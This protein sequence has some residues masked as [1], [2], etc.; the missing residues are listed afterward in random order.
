MTTTRIVTA[1]GLTPL[2]E[3]AIGDVDVAVGDAR[4]DTARYDEPD[5]VY[6]GLA[7]EFVDA[8]CNVIEAA[9]YCG[10]ERTI[11]AFD[12]GT[13][14]LIVANDDGAWDFP[15][16]TP[17]TAAVT[18]R[19]G[20]QCRVGVDIGDGPRW[21]FHGWI[22]RTEP[23]YKPGVGDTVTVEAV[24]AK[25]EVG[26]VE[27]PRKLAAVGVG[28]TVTARLTRLCDAANF[29]THRRVFDWSAITL[30][31]T[32]FGNRVAA[33][34]DSAAQSAGGA[35]FG[36]HAGLLRFRN[37]DWL[38]WPTGTTADVTIGNTA[39]A[40]VCPNTW[41]IRFARSDFATRVEYGRVGEDP[42]PPID[43]TVNQASYGVE[44]YI[45]ASLETEDT[46]D[47]DDIGERIARARSFDRAPRIAAVTL[48]AARPGA[49]AVMAAVN[50][51]DPTLVAATL[52]EDDGRVV[53]TR[54]SYVTGVEHTITA[55]AWLC[56]IALDDA[57][58]FHQGFDSRYDAADYDLDRYTMVV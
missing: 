51:F 30:I 7:G 5:A 42:R 47:L 35:V 29:P 3:V 1:P 43:D 48:D 31:G 23:T 6:G 22:D 15:P 12:V 28:E 39:T 57:E 36:D 58:P 55:G 4:Y 37:R 21:L 40:D 8:S 20:R 9:L 45:A 41:E 24:D 49:A 19:P 16:S 44:T 2:L 52:V 32:T 17:P 13:A 11:E 25:G 14:T 26:R 34:A 54:M 33:L 53:F 18:T 46:A 10:R 27:L 50:P 38:S 56:R